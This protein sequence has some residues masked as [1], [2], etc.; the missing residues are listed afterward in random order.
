MTMTSFFLQG[1]VKKP[2]ATHVVYQVVLGHEVPPAIEKSVQLQLKRASIG[3]PWPQESRDSGI[4]VDCGSVG[5]VSQTQTPTASIDVEKITSDLQKFHAGKR[6]SASESSESSQSYSHIAKTRPKV[7]HVPPA[8]VWS[9]RGNTSIALGIGPYSG[10]GDMKVQRW[11]LAKSVTSQLP[12]V[13]MSTRN[14]NPIKPRPPSPDS[15]KSES[16]SQAVAS[17]MARRGSGGR[18]SGFSRGK[19]RSRHNTGGSS[20]VPSESAKKRED[21]WKGERRRG[22]GG[23]QERRGRGGGQRQGQQRNSQS[24]RVE[25]NDPEVTDYRR[26]VS[27]PDTK[28][29]DK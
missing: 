28:T 20:G 25:R 7:L 23:Y 16:E 6:P 17:S 1:N 27:T 5:G 22:R 4:N 3:S 18:T 29:R 19:P 26:T 13:G 8:G 14:Q 12:M 2:R 10:H 9:D 15:W 21:S 24:L 11:P